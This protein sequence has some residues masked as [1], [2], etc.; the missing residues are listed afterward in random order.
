MLRGT[1]Q[2][3][4]YTDFDKAYVTTVNSPYIYIQNILIKN[5]AI[6]IESFKEY[7]CKYVNIF[8]RTERGIRNID[9]P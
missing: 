4:A 8:V 5:S 3:K 9:T 6:I 1:H 7:I 2:V